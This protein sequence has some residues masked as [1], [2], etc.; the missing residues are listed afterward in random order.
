[1]EKTP[2]WLDADKFF[3]KE[4]IEAELPGCK[5]EGKRKKSEDKV[6]QEAK[7]RM[8]MRIYGANRTRALKII[9]KGK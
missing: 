2:K 6:F 4:I 1:M 7:I 9:G 3:D 5:K 8:V